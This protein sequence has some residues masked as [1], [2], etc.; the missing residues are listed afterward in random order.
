[1][2]KRNGEEY[3]P[4]IPAPQGNYADGWVWESALRGPTPAPFRPP[5][6]LFRKR[7]DDNVARE[8]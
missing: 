4:P 5:F 6:F 2:E 3:V 7:T 1:M 8:G